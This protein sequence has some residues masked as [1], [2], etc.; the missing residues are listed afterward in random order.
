[1]KYF[2]TALFF[3]FVLPAFAQQVLP[4]ALQGSTE[5]GVFLEN[6]RTIQLYPQSENGASRFLSPIIPLG[7]ENRLF[8][9][10]DELGDNFYTYSFKIY[11]CTADWKLSD[12]S[13]AEFLN[14]YNEF[15]I[16]DMQA[17]VGTKVP[18]VHYFA[19][20]P[21]ITK[22]G[23][24]LLVAF[25][26]DDEEVIAFTRRFMVYENRVGIGSLLGGAVGVEQALRQQRLD[27][28]VQLGKLQVQVP[29]DQVKLVV[30]QNQRWDNALTG[31][32]PTSIRL[33][34]NIYDYSYFGD[35]S[36]KG[37]NEFRM[38]DMRLPD[39]GGFGV[40]GFAMED[41][42]NK[43]ITEIQKS[44]AGRVY[45]RMYNDMNGQFSIEL[46]LNGNAD[47]D[48]DY[49]EVLFQLD[50]PEGEA[51]APLYLVGE[52]TNWKALEEFR[53]KVNPENGLFYCNPLLK[54]GLYNYAFALRQPD[55]SLDLSTLESDHRQTE[56]EYEILV[57]YRPFGGRTDYLYGYRVFR[58]R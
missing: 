56:N 40:Q 9:S 34:E 28:R 42:A 44:R 39:A 20:L 29:E 7:S 22:P 16:L 45:N 25:D 31:L 33:H 24:Y 19:T 36:F 37:G 30:R 58:Q 54:Q 48:A 27:L 46:R 2:F 23:N 6:I 43:I 57:Y 55:G 17:S 32:A 47:T 4:D 50:W 15:D 11:N 52:M 14:D 18:Y 12:L 35:D 8:L 3:L 41:K 13:D 21:Q 5:E 1:M 51:T 53:L 10:F 38:L 26:E 49:F